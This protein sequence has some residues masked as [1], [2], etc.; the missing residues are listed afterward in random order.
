M[1]LSSYLYRVGSALRAD[2]AT[3]THNHPYVGTQSRPYRIQPKGGTGERKVSPAAK[4][5]HNPQP[6]PLNPQPSTPASD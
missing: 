6:A 1:P 3:P 4:Q 5:R 2:L